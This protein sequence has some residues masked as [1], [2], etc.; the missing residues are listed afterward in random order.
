MNCQLCSLPIGIKP[1][2]EGEH[3][4][5]CIGC[6][7]VYRLLFSEGVV[8]NYAQHPLF[9]QAVRAGLISNPQLIEEI[10]K[11][12]QDS[13]KQEVRRWH[14][15]I[16]DMWCSTC[17]EVIKWILLKEKGI[18]SCSVDYSVDLAFIEYS[19]RHLSK[20]QIVLLIQKLG[21]RVQT[22]ENPEKRTVSFDLYLRAIVAGFCALNIMMFAYPVYASYFTDEEIVFSDLFSWLSFGL[23]LPVLFY[24]GWPIW[25]RAWNGL[26]SKI[27]G[28]E[29]LVSMGVWAA[30]LLSCYELIQGSH[31]I[32]FDSMTVI[33]AFVLVGKIIEARAKFSAKETL[34]QLNRSLP[35]RGRKKNEDGSFQFVSLKELQT[36]D[37]VSVFTGEKIVIDGVI[38]EGEGQCDESL[39]T[40]EFYPLIKRIGDRV[41][42]GSLLVQ[43]MLTIKMTS[44]SEQSTVHQIVDIVRSGISQKSVVPRLE[45]CVVKVFI[46]FVIFSSLLAVVWGYFLGNNDEGMIR[47]ISILLIACPCAIGIA[48][49]L[50]ESYL[51]NS[52]VS[53]GAVIRNLDVIK[54]IGKEHLFVF[55]KT[56]TVTYGKFTVLNGIEQLEDTQKAVLKAMTLQST[57]PIAGSISRTINEKPVDLCR[58]EELIGEGIHAE[59][60][61]VPYDLGSSAYMQRL[62]VNVPDFASSSLVTPVYFVENGEFQSVIQLGDAIREGVKELLQDLKPAKTLL[63]SGDRSTTVEHVAG[64]CQFDHWQGEC[65]P[66]EKKMIIEKHCA[67]GLVV[68]FIGDGINDAPALTAS[69]VGI[70][71][72]SASDISVHVSDIL[73][74]TDRLS[75]LKTLR[76]RARCARKLIKQN[77]FWAFFY[78]VIGILL[79]ALG[80]LTPIYAAI[81]MVLSSLIVILNSER[82][83]L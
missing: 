70:S 22:L 66:L 24:S 48:V 44:A 65:T 71:V 81:A 38:V 29:L 76:E 80:V 21:Y 28:M 40:G 7:A 82:V 36:G 37:I 19:P 26:R 30:F 69:S 25:R 32:Y 74:T 34:Y 50:V 57:H 75:I 59:I 60:K 4:F 56:G 63:L 15:E 43:G 73:L 45:D 49:P 78:N 41:L 18:I 23:S 47:A 10:Q 11:K 9:E 33:I 39:V 51:L 79:A 46:P 64:L 6:Q 54:M 2:R 55:D 27:M 17:A 14:I 62:G 8:E 83:H 77:L 67:E 16:L 72:V 1:I 13:P 31:Q 12:R 35:K 42:G 20:E 68:C 3:H 52:L 58:V 61:G 5:C 53:S